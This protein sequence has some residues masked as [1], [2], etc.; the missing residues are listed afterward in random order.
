VVGPTISAS[1]ALEIDQLIDDGNLGTGNF[2][3]YSNGYTYVMAF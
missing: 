3:S 2:R 1:Q